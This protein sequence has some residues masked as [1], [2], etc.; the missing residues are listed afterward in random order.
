MKQKA[1]CSM[2]LKEEVAK[3]IGVYESVRKNDAR[4]KVSSHESGRT[5]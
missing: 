5:D 4:R 1:V 2:P 3:I